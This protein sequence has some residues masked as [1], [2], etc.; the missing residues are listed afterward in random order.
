MKEALKQKSFWLLAIGWPGTT[1]IWIAMFYYWPSY[2]TEG[3][4]LTMEKA[5]FV[6]SFIPIFSAI[7]SCACARQSPDTAR[8]ASFPSRL[9]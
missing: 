3:A 5:G 4:G 2:I 9:P 7:A 8:T 6:L 1:L